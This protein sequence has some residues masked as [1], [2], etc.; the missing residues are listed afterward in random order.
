[1]ARR[2]S[3]QQDELV[4][5]PPGC[6]DDNPDCRSGCNWPG[7]CLAPRIGAGGCFRNRH[8][9]EAYLASGG[10]VSAVERAR[11]ALAEDEYWRGL[12]V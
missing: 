11:E 10:F 12:R 3:T 6:R 4:L 9:C 5:D 2:R 8:V 1:M 7:Q